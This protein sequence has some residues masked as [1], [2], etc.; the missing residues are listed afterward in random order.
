MRNELI[1]LN[2]D[3]CFYNFTQR[4]SKMGEEEGDAFQTCIQTNEIVFDYLLASRD[5]KSLARL[6]FYLLDQGLRAKIA[7]EYF[8]QNAASSDQLEESKKNADA[9]AASIEASFKT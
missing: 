3:E 8:I 5:C 9:A 1:D 7:N 2:L 4:P 6:A